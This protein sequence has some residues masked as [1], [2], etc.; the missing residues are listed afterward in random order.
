MTEIITEVRSKITF[1]EIPQDLQT[2]ALKLLKSVKENN[3]Q[4]AK[5][6]EKAVYY[7][8]QIGVFI[9]ML[10]PSPQMKG[11]RIDFGEK[12][13]CSEQDTETDL[14]RQKVA[15]YI[16]ITG[17]NP[18]MEFFNYLNSLGIRFSQIS[19]D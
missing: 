15:K 10:D 5:G 4:A 11:A 9:S 14:N 16:E 6:F 17:Q 8:K 1:V 13:M 19:L 18:S 3:K 7:E 2:Q 12:Q